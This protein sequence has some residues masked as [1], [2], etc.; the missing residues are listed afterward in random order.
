MDKLKKIYHTPKSQRTANEVINAQDKEGYSALH[1]SIINSKIEAAEYIIQIGANV[2][3]AS[4]EKD[5]FEGNTPLISASFHGFISIVKKL[6]ING[7][8]IGAKRKSGFHAAEA[9]A[10]EGNLEVL[11]FLIREELQVVDQ[12]GSDGKTPLIAAAR[13][14]HLNIVKYLL[15]H[16]QVDI[17]SQ[18]NDGSSPLM[19]ASFNNR[20]EVV[21][22]LV[23]EG[24]NI[25]LKAKNGGH[26]AYIAA[27]EG[28]LKI[29]KFLVQN[30]PDVVDMKGFKGRTPLGGAVI[31][32]H[33]NVVKYLIS[34]PNVDIDSQEN[35]GSTPLILA[36]YFNHL[37]VVRFLFKNGADTSIK[38]IDGQTALHYYYARSQDFFKY[39]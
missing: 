28:N 11:Q 30:A 10:Q 31:D 33:L 18:D 17:D 35:D 14:G 1:W 7:A 39:Y 26:A 19:F 16:Q 24:A 3:T 38:D 32:G 25:K 6:V 5:K 27:Q 8:N 9:A 23:Q 15:S 36:A 22:F 12:K 4:N 21:K 13:R 37:N 29:L 34:Q 2:N 20:T